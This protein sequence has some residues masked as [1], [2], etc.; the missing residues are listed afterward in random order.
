[1]D[2][3]IAK[4]TL[5]SSDR[6]IFEDKNTRKFRLYDSVFK[7]VLTYASLLF[8]ALLIG[9]FITL[10]IKSLPSIET[11][12]LSYYTGTVWDP[13]NIEFGSLPFLVGTLITSFLA[14]AITIPF[15]LSIS[16][17]LGEYFKRGIVSSFLRNCVELLGGIPSVI[18]G[19]WGLFFLVPIVRSLE[20]KIG[21]PPLGIGIFT[22]S[23][24]LFVMIIPYSASIGREVI[25]LVPS[26]QKEAALSLGSTK[27]EVIKSVILPYARSG[28]FAGILLALG[29]ALG[30]TMA[31][32]MVIGN[33][34]AIPKSIFSP[35][36][37]MASVI[38]N[39]FT[40]ATGDVYVSSLIQI[41]LLLFIV[42]TIISII[43][44]KIIK[45]FS[46][47]MQ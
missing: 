11:F 25:S 34:N 30:E 36:S 18:Y 44:K 13:V 4:E 24:L 17:F 32:T 47:G 29:R 12:G 14:L 8:I 3:A 33:S 43:G 19:F 27:Y 2:S 39:E 21:L 45:R 15:S 40:E 20:E 35:A 22:T 5:I 46:R 6:V 9:M 37:T 26:S 1:M 7:K 16:L 38:A 23:I 41:G 10:L 28:I 42:T 31:V